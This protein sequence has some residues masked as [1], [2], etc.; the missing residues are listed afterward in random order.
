M[1]NEKEAMKQ[2]LKEIREKV[3]TYR[4]KVLER[5]RIEAEKRDSTVKIPKED[6][7]A[8]KSYLEE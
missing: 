6:W 3:E 5:K 4:S 1:E 2:E 7:E 8:L